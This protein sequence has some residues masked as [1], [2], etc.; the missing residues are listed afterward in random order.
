M[1]IGTTFKE[2]NTSKNLIKNQFNIMN[3]HEQC[4]KNKFQYNSK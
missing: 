2:E 4:L 1:I 3:V